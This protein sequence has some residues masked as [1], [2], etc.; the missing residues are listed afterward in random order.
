MSFLYIRQLSRQITHR[1]RITPRVVQILAVILFLHITSFS[2]LSQLSIKTESGQT[3]GFF[4]ESHALLIGVSDYRNGWPDLESI[5]GDI[6]LLEKTLK[7]R[8]FIV[9]TVKDPDGKTL[10]Q[11]YE[12]FINAYGYNPENRLLFYFAGHGHTMDDG[13]RGY[14]VPV[15]APIP[16]KDPSNFKRKA[17]DMNQIISWCRQMDAK[18]ALFLFDSCFSGTIF[19]QRDL[20]KMPPQI[21]MLTGKPVRQFI[22]AGSA[23]E[24]VPAKST[25]TP[26]FV[27]ALTYGTADLNKDG[28]ITGTELGV[29]LQNL[30]MSYVQQT[31]Q[32]GKIPDY[33]LS[34]GDFVFASPGSAASGQAGS[35][36][37]PQA[38]LNPGTSQSKRSVE[39]TAI[40]GNT[41]PAPLELPETPRVLIHT[42]GDDDLLALFT[43]QL[44]SA[45]MTSGLD[46]CSTTSIPSLGILASQGKLNANW[47]EINQYVSDTNAQILVTAQIKK[48]GSR[49]IEFYGQKTTLHTAT[50]VI[51]AVD[52]ASGS[53]A[54]TPE[55]GQINYTDLNMMQ[56]IQKTVSAGSARLG[57]NIKNYWKKKRN[58]N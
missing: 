40:P 44:E 53:L 45:F 46:Y 14:L 22:T 6:K 51:K 57:D 16:Y 33:E 23:G 11:A 8:G 49:K 47:S 24:S 50:F 17:L 4:N 36:H 27:D 56:T 9:Q 3:V 39:I 41:P 1:I 38:S 7:A 2:A 28:F 18:H 25:F 12:S 30:S 34:R 35:G 5:P 10:K 19:K 52:M 32:Y 43:A 37:Q 55:S 13:S 26:A 15:D 31:P 54:A 48:T 42:H 20:P 29:Y 58:S 21:S